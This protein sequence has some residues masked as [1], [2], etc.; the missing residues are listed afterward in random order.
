VRQL[1]VS[2]VRAYRATL[3]QLVPPGRC[4]YHPSC[5]QY[6]IDAFSEFG[7][8]RGTVLATWRLLR[9]N[10]WSHGGVDYAADQRLFDRR[11]SPG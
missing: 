9:C 3:G 11:R 10:P 5:S 4:K 8:A 7:L 2:A 6:A 1:G